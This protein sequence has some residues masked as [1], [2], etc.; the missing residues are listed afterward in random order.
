[1][2]AQ[3]DGT[4]S[5]ARAVR[6]EQAALIRSLARLGQFEAADIHQVRV[7]GRRLRSFLKTCRRLFEPEASSDYRRALKSLADMLGRLRELDVLRGDIAPLG[8]A[9]IT[10]EVDRERA[11]ATRGVQRRLR[12]ARMADTTG[13]L[14]GLRGASVLGLRRDVTAAELF[15][16]VRR[17]CRRVHRLAAAPP[18]STEALHELRIDI[19]NLR[20][21]IEL[22]DL[23]TE[24]K[25]REF[26][27]QLRI[28]QN[29]LGEHRDVTVAREWL[30]DRAPGLPDAE[31]QAAQVALDT[32]ERRLRNEARRAVR[33]VERSCRHWL[34]ATHARA[35]S[36][37]AR[38]GRAAP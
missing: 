2:S 12:G 14:L 36:R 31:V 9:G 33:D 1:V 16:R 6:R 35:V 23:F 28:A 3:S 29:R 5:I 11:R 19:K 13:T 18:A 15:E 21:A 7:H 26:V 10:T 20:Y 4:R 24:E 22:I 8:F 34:G 17:Q 38:P 37:R 27:R 32:R 25:D 30:H